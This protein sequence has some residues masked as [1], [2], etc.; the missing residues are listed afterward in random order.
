MAA[1][2]GWCDGWRR[3]LPAIF[4]L[5]AAV[6]SFGQEYRATITG[7]VTDSTKAVI[8]NATVSVRNLDTG[9]IIRV[10]TNKAGAYTVPFLHPGH[11]LEVSADASGFKRSTFPPI[12]LAVSQTQ[13]ADFSPMPELSR[14]S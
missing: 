10:K 11:K 4:I 2:S 9:E 8:P 12:V 3:L 5:L 13:T 6:V 1:R 7:I 14:R